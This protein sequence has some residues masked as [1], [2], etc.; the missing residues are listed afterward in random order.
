VKYE[1]HFSNPCLAWQVFNCKTNLGCKVTRIQYQNNEQGKQ[2]EEEP[3]MVVASAAVEDS[4][5]IN[6]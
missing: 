2:K 3:L 1:Q 5:S 6:M 4:S